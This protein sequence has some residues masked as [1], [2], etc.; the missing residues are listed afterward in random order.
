MRS[1]RAMRSTASHA[2]MGLAMS[3]VVWEPGAV[4]AQTPP[5]LDVASPVGEVRMEEVA[6]L[7][8]GGLPAAPDALARVTAR[9]SGGW[10]VSGPT[11]GGPVYLFDAD[12]GWITSV[13]RTGQGPG[14][15][16]LPP[17][18]VP[19]GDEIWL[20]DPGNARV[21][22]VGPDGAVRGERRVEG[23]VMG[24]TSGAAGDRALASGGFPS[25]DGESGIL[26]WIG[27]TPEEDLV[28]GEVRETENPRAQ[29]GLGIDTG[30]EVW[31][32]AVMG[33][34]VTIHAPDLKVV[35]RATMPIEAMLE[36][37]PA[38]PL[39]ISSVRPPPQ[40]A[41][42]MRDGMGGIWVVTIVASER[43][44]EGVTPADGIDAIYDTRFLRIDPATRM[45]THDGRTDAVCQPVGAG[46]VSCADEAGEAI[47]LQ[48]LRVRPPADLFDYDRTEPL[49]TEV[50]D[51][52]V[53]EG[54]RRVDVAWASP[55]GGRVPAFLYLPDG[56]GPHP[57]V[58]L[59]HG[60]PGH[61]GT[62]RELAQEYARAGAIALT[63]AASF[64]R[65][66][67][68][69]RDVALFTM[70]QFDDRDRRELVQTVKDLRR[71]VDLLEAR[72]DVDP[73]RI[74]FVGASWG[75]WVGSVLA[76]IERRISAFGLLVAPTSLGPRFLG[77][78]EFAEVTGWAA[79][80]DGRRA[81]WLAT[82][83]DLDGRLFVGSADGA[84]LR[85]DIATDDALVPVD[86][87]RALAAAAPASAEVGEW[88]L[89]HALSPEVYRAQARWLAPI[90]GL[91][92]DGFRGP[93]YRSAGSGGGRSAAVLRVDAPGR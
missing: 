26:M 41:G 73:E 93:D 19:I 77:S 31:A 78:E 57:A 45:L 39:D 30:E 20:L 80:S 27:P 13:G 25:G 50:G 71:A 65:P 68:I 63:P 8:F 79:L 47:R 59:Q 2:L 56:E 23:R 29:F 86:D 22:R 42:V 58:I 61:R 89:G 35:D 44:R 52:V 5:A 88:D 38:G 9:P 10:A 32:F 69:Y 64:S 15:F 48:R 11:L 6:V 40:V 83:A 74:A 3:G 72:P 90:L 18:G 24:V 76:G 81:S 28:G 85:F 49:D 4:A 33:G 67:P 60:M 17:F 46:V 70:P 7:D 14:E 1:M 75:G 54:V 21:T 87:A 16:A 62:F 37:P 91:D 36:V 53:V 92:V 12:G 55:D 43:W 51:V 82:M 84:R 66:D 34:V